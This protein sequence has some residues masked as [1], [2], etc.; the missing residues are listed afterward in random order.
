MI[1]AWAAK[2]AAAGRLRAE[3]MST[4]SIDIRPLS[5]SLGAEIRG[6]DLARPL[7]AESF[8]RLERAFLDHLVLFFRDQELTPAQQV[9]FAARFGPIGRYPLAEPIPEHPDIIAVIKEPGQTTN[10]G[11]VWHSDTAYLEAP[12]LGSLLYAKEVPA[13]G[14]DTLFANM[15]LAYESLSPG[16][17]RLLDGLRAVNGAAKNHETLRF[18]H[19]AGGAM[20]GTAVDPHG[21]QAEHPVVRRHPV[22]GRKALYVNRAHTLRFANMTEAE[23]AGLLGYLF[24][25]AAR[26]E[27]TCRFQWQAG[28][29]ALWDNRCSQHYPLND[30]HGQRRVMHRVTIEGDRPA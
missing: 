3:S 20:T 8:G 21:L 28:S 23:S 26:E 12:S 16:L 17:R 29:L 9:A 11:G 15:Y 2:E 10:F 30:Y 22:T 14:G 1:S 25:H 6:V 27:F 13:R 7:D 18:D 4:T 19:L 24:E 5:G